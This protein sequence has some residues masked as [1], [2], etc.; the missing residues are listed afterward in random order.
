MKFKKVIATGA[1]LVAL[2]LALTA[3]GS[4]SSKSGLADKQVLN[5]SYASELPSMDLST[6]TDTISFDQLNSTMEGIYRIGKNSKVEPGLATKTEVSKDGLT[7]TFTLRKND[8][9]S[10]GDPVTAQDFVYSW[11]RTVDPKTGSQYAY[12]FDGIANANDIIAGKK[13]VDTLGI[14]AEG[15]Y[16]LVVTLEKKLPYFKLLMGFP[17]FFPQNQ[18]VVEKYGKKYGTAAKYL[19]YNGPFKMEGWSGSNLSWKLVKNKNYWDKKD[20]KLSQI[21]FSVNKSTTTSYNLYQSKKLDYTPLSTEQAKQLKG[22]DG[23]RVLKEA[24]TNY[25][26]FNETN[27]VFANKKIRQALS[28]AVN[29]QV[30]ADKVLGAGTLPSLGIVSRDLAFNKGKD[31]AVAAK[32]TA[33]VTYNKAKA[34]KLLKEGLAEVGQSKLS[35]TLLGD[36]TDVSKQVTESLQSQIQQTLPDVDVSVSNVPFKTRLQR[37]EDG[38]FDVVV[39]AWGADFAD[40]ISFLDLFTSDNSYNNGK[41]KNA[42]YDKLIT[43][44]KTTD[45]GNV[46]KRWDDM[47]KASKIL[48]E[49]QGVAP[50]YQLNVAYMLNPSVKGVIQNTAGVTWSFK[51]AYIANK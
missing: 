48:S 28:Y 36:D 3:C 51:D 42:E 9:W 16:K 35:F 18:N 29:R 2:G 26:E 23:Y 43:A 46:D 15:K 19:V 49:D 40:P 21:N 50:L 1:S 33:G 6:A 25:L 10:N 8:K 24:R 45:A 37:S 7:Y 38:D 27:K 4:N 11:R 14:K 31:F 41:W 5:W 13:A 47:V 20:V 12:L 39:S 32:T 30:L 34:Q 17:V 22:K 44:S